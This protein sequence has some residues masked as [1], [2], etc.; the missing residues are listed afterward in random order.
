[1]RENSSTASDYDTS[2]KACA[3]VMT[4]DTDFRKRLFRTCHASLSAGKQRNDTITHA[5]HRLVNSTNVSFRYNSRPM[6]DAGS[7]TSSGS[8]SSDLLNW[9]VLAIWVFV[10]FSF[11]AL[12]PVGYVIWANCASL[13]PF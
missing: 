8:P 13:S 12:V 9:E 5:L 4:S 10:A 2:A 1:M 11:A 6:L 7:A 3:G